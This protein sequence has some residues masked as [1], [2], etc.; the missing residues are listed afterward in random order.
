MIKIIHLSDFHLDGT[1]LPK[2]KQRLTRALLDDLNTYIDAD[3]IVA[4][5]GDLI[6][7]GGKNFQLQ[8]KGRIAPFDSFYK[9]FVEPIVKQYPS[10]EQKIFLVPG[11]HDINRGKIE[12]ISE[13]GLKSVL[14]N[15][16]T[17]DEFIQERIKKDDFRHLER[18]EDYKLFEKTFY[19]NYPVKCITNFHSS[20]LCTIGGKSIGISCFNSAWLCRDDADR[21]NLLMGKFQIEDSLTFIANADVKIALMHHPV[22]FL[23]D[24]D[25]SNAKQMLQGNYNILLNGHTHEL[26]SELT[27]SIAGN[28]F[29]SIASST[30]GDP[31]NRELIY[32]YT[33]IEY[34]LRKKKILLRFRKYVDAHSKFLNHNEVGNNE[35]IKE[36]KIPTTEQ[37]QAYQLSS[38]LVDKL[39][40]V[41]Q[42]KLNEDLIIYNSG[43]RNPFTI[44]SIFVQPTISNYP[45]NS[46]YEN[47]EAKTYSIED[48]IKHEGNF[49]V[50][51]L[52]ESG[53]T[54]LADKIFLDYIKRFEE[55]RTI[56]I[57]LKFTAFKNYEIERLIKDFLQESS[58]DT[59]SIIKENRLV[60]IVDDISFSRKSPD[61]L[62]RLSAFLNT[63][64]NVKLIATSHQNI[65]SVIPAEYLSYNS[66][67]QFTLG[68]IQS[69]GAKEIKGL[70]QNWFAGQDIDFHENLE[71]L[72]K[73]FKDLE[74]PRTPLAVT[75]FLWIIE[76]QER[77]P[78][79]NSTL[80]Q[81]FIENLLEKANFEEVYSESFDF[82]NKLR[83]LA[84]FAKYVLDHGDEENNYSVEMHDAI[85]FLQDYVKGK[86]EIN[87]STLLQNLVNRG[88]LSYQDGSNIRFK[89]SC[90]FHYFLAVYMEHSEDFKKFTLS[91]DNYLDFQE[92]I[93]YYTGLKRDATDVLEFT[94]IQLSRAFL[95]LNEQLISHPDEIDSF[96]DTN[97][98]LSAKISLDRVKNKP[99]EQ[100]LDKMFDD[101][102]KEI[103]VQKNIPKKGKE[104]ANE[105]ELDKILRLAAIVLKNCEEV[106]AFDKRVN[107]FKNIILSSIS[108]LTLYKQALIEFLKDNSSTPNHLPKNVN[109]DFL[110]RILPLMHQVMLQDWL[111]T[112][113]LKAVISKKIDDDKTSVN[114]S[115]LEKFFSIFIYSDSR[116]SGYTQVIKDYFK[117]VRNDYI[118]DL[119]FLKLV[120]Y[121]FLR[122]K[123]KESDKF[124][125][126]LIADIKENLGQITK[127]KKG[128]FIQKLEK[129]KQLKL[130]QK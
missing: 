20:F 58:E 112:P 128:E 53:K 75:L 99:T 90:F 94:Q 72:I 124:Y 118:Y 54:I 24:F 13:E 50:Y 42:E 10:I 105:L 120:S 83:M 82:K 29:T 126:N 129:E 44:D 49:L 46:N 36:I 119:M 45:E 4:F 108:F 78:I 1:E 101:Q 76:K 121:Y 62:A 80:V 68:F 9:H 32:G 113:K 100:Q 97:N 5:T 111:G 30:I 103:P 84:Y 66:N 60:L 106:D 91:P 38:S 27:Q 12:K 67:F 6:N 8:D 3:T 89:S 125:L 7:K 17:L 73:H 102:L 85:K 41:M 23:K 35:G 63:H 57:L 47:T 52:K 81:L 21:G 115:E 37:V 93:G 19:E 123:T 34:D 130:F 11:N 61:Q 86:F 33:V 116:A 109:L 56:P 110:V 22:T 69:L 71:K 74:L 28:L 107:A 43:T 55:L 77:K 51:G 59:K 70:I 87:P 88:L 95:D 26:E 64:S 122:S 98:A 16:E 40:G 79:N 2:Q 31:S 14:N 18:I 92:E 15:P 114:I 104:T 48:I 65:E 25:Y 117:R 96:F 39:E 127:K